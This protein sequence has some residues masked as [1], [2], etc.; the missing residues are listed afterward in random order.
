SDPVH[1][2][3]G[4]GPPPRREDDFSAPLVVPAGLEIELDPDVPGGVEVV[5]RGRIL[6]PRLVHRSPEVGS[7]VAAAGLFLALADR[8][9]LV[10]V[11][12]RLAPT[13]VPDLPEEPPED[14]PVLVKPGRVLDEILLDV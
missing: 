14:V 3:P 1:V 4:R 6:G 12:R 10:D 8:G 2:P 9:A 7:G 13:V 11:G 5:P